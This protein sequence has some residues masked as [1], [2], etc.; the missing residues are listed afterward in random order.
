VRERYLLGAGLIYCT[1]VKALLAAYESEY[2]VITP[3]EIQAAG[4]RARSRAVAVRPTPQPRRTLPKSGAS[5]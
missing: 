4:R 2:G 5:R 1:G 3:E